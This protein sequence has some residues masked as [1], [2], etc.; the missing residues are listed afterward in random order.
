MDSANIVHKHVYRRPACCA[1]VCM[2]YMYVQCGPESVERRERVWGESTGIVSL[3][4]SHRNMRATRAHWYAPAIDAREASVVDCRASGP[5]VPPRNSIFTPRIRAECHVTLQPST[6]DQP[7]LTAL[8][9]LALKQLGLQSRSD[10]AARPELNLDLYKSFAAAAKLAVIPAY[11]KLVPSCAAIE[12]ALLSLTSDSLSWKLPEHVAHGVIY[13]LFALHEV[14][15][16]DEVVENHNLQDAHGPSEAR[17]HI[18]NVLEEDAASKQA[19]ATRDTVCAVLRKCSVDSDSTS[20]EPTSRNVGGASACDDPIGLA[21]RE[22]DA[23]SSKVPSPLP[24]PL[25][26]LHSGIH[27]HCLVCGGVVGA[28]APMPL[29]APC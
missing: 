6:S 12:L 15:Y 14:R 29:C 1:R 26:V 28:T 10:I 21:Q 24:W 17:L 27:R 18:R 8:D 2:Q 7:T 22:S 13:A 11:D 4:T 5:L 20:P 3:N 16:E 23:A 9:R 25:A 19:E